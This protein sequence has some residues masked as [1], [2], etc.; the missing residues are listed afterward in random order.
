PAS[1]WACRRTGLVPG[2]TWAVRRCVQ[3][4]AGPPRPW[5]NLRR[6]PLGSGRAFRAGMLTNLLNPKVGV[7]Y[8]SLLPQFLPTGPAAPA[9][10]ALLVA[11]HVAIGLGWLGGM[12]LLADR[13]RRLLLRER[14][15]LWLDRTTAGV[16]VGLGVAMVADAR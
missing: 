5:A 9:W 4:G 13:A 8:L 15:R 10:G 7:F 2:C 14:V 6:G 1:R 11:L 12:V 3:R 16:L